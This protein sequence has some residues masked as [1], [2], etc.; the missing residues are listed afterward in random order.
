[1]AVTVNVYEESAIR[2]IASYGFMHQPV[3]TIW[4]NGPD[5]MFVVLCSTDVAEF[6]SAFTG[7]VEELMAA[8]V[9]E[10]ATG[11]GYFQQGEKVFLSRFSSASY[12]YWASFIRRDYSQTVWSGI[13]PFGNGYKCWPNTTFAERFQHGKIRYNDWPAWRST[14]GISAK[15]ALLCMELPNSSASTLYGRSRP[16]AMI[17]FGGTRTGSVDYDVANQA[18]VKMIT[19]NTNGAINWTR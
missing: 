16:L 9:S 12:Q 19:W 15:S 17:D 13:F 8:G 10:I 14:G 7:T 3:S 4:S 2:T 6:D 18:W 1:M 11:N 5:K